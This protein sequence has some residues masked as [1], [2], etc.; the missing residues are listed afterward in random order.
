MFEEF[1]GH[2]RIGLSIECV[3]MS[4][5]HSPELGIILYDSV[6]YCYEPPIR[7]CMRVAIVFGYP[8][9]GRPTGMSDSGTASYEI[10]SI[11]LVF[12]FHDFTDSFAHEYFMIAVHYTDTGA[13]I[14]TVLQS[15]K[16]FDEDGGSILVSCKSEYSA[17]IDRG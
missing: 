1:H 14:S 3:S 4:L 9:M 15:G 16:S 11:G 8:S 6:V 7:R 2:F 13:I 5:E 12:E 10:H 17:H